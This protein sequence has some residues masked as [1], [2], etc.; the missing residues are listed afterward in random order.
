[1]QSLNK[2]KTILLKI[3]FKYSL[4]VS[5]VATG[6]FILWINEHFMHSL[7]KDRVISCSEELLNTV[8]NTRIFY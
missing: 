4:Y 6:Y 5:K 7:I 8:H 1:M 2:K 3:T